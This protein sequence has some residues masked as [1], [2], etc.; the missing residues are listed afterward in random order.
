MQ[1]KYF[2]L[3]SKLFAASMLLGRSLPQVSGKKNVAKDPN[4]LIAPKT[5]RGNSVW[6]FA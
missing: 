3:T 1:S 6:N 4:I 5:R 2:W